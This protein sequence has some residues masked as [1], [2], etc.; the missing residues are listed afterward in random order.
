MLSYIVPLSTLVLSYMDSLFPT[1]ISD[2]LSEFVFR[3]ISLAISFSF[4]YFIYRFVPNKHLPRFARLVSTG[5]AVFLFELSRNI[6]AFYLTSVS[7][8]P[9]FYGAYAMLAAMAI[10]IYYSTL[11]LLLS[12]EIG[13]FIYELRLRKKA[14]KKLDEK[15]PAADESGW[16]WMVA[17]CWWKLLRGGTA[18][19]SILGQGIRWQ[20]GEIAW[21]E[22]IN[23][24]HNTGKVI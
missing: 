18:K 3:V 2:F 6:F 5:L 11:I 17:D 21:M 10:W 16:R 19:K 12:G 23:K 14:E 9:R 15:K 13:Q 22:V 4:F 7:N 20:E 24:L 1:Y 8:Y